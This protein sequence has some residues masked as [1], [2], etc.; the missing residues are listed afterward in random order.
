M[1]KNI[2]TKDVVLTDV[3]VNDW[4]GAVKVCG[5]LLVDTHKITGQ[6]IESMTRTVE[7]FGPYMILLPEIAL[8][9]GRPD[10][11]VN[12]IC[13]S[14]VTFG[15]EVGFKEFGNEVI[16]AAFA[17]GAT[18]ENSH[19]EVLREMAL[20]LQDEIFIDLL[21]NHGNKNQIMDII[22]KY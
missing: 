10:E 13:L 15:E 12:E 11:G 21:K 17:F 20:L 7:K 1:I 3:Y 9:H 4:R 6:Y 16:R 19:I 18:D 2:L 14:L 22:N 8:F 5:K